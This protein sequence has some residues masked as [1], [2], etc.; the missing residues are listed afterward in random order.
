MRNL[1]F[2]SITELLNIFILHRR[3]ERK[4]SEQNIGAPPSYEETLSDARSPVQ[5]ERFG[6]WSIH[7]LVSTFYHHLQ[8]I[9]TF[10][11][12]KGLEKLQQ[13]LFIKHPLHLESQV[14]VKQLLCITL[15]HLQQTRKLMVLMNLTREV[16][17]QVGKILFI[18]SPLDAILNFAISCLLITFH[19]G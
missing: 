4:F 14:K 3:L 1:I 12:M 18:C 7:A 9:L 2:P 16:L 10:S 15:Q 11:S 8:L 19:D 13:H 6:L 5:D 17:S